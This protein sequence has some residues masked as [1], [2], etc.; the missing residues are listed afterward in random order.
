VAAILFNAGV[1]AVLLAGHSAAALNVRYGLMPLPYLPYSKWSGDPLVGDRPEGFMVDLLA[2]LG[3]YLKWNLTFVPMGPLCVMNAA[4]QV[5]GG[6]PKFATGRDSYLHDVRQQLVDDKFDLSLLYYDDPVGG[7]A[8]ALRAVKQSVAY[9][10]Q[11]HS[12]G[13]MKVQTPPP[14]L[15]LFDPFTA[16]LWGA[17]LAFSVAYGALLFVLHH[18]ASVVNGGG[19][20]SGSGGPWSVREA[21]SMQ[22]HALAMVLAGEALDNWR[23]RA[24]RLARLGMLLFVLVFGATYT[25]N[26]AAF[27]T[28]PAFRL[29]GPTTAAALGAA[30]VCVQQAVVLPVVRQ[31]IGSRCRRRRSRPRACS[32][33]SATARGS[34]S[35][36]AAAWRGWSG[37]S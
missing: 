29:V 14:L 32:R 15:A 6:C 25:A 5:V 31:S 12:V 26:L 1:V 17:I 36:P 2:E 16:D 37:C 10:T 35:T 3:Q 11:I 34:C 21:L 28:K 7:F 9:H 33:S 13:I 30:K 24:L 4:G 22:Y 19:S 8:P 18:A 23:S 27:F 20:G